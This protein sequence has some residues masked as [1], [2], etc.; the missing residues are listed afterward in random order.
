MG[1]LSLHISSPC[2]L[3]GAQARAVDPVMPLRPP[4]VRGALR[5]WFRMGAA[6]VLLVPE[7]RNPAAERN[8]I[9]LLHQAE[10]ELF[11]NTTVRSRVVI[12]APTGGQTIGL[13]LDEQKWPGLRYLG[14]GLFEDKRTPSQALITDSS[15]M[16]EPVRLPRLGPISLPI[17]LKPRGPNDRV[18]DAHR[19]LLAATLWLWLHLGGLGARS[20]RGWGSLRLAQPS[21]LLEGVPELRAKGP[22]DIVRGLVQGL[23]RATEIFREELP[24]LGIVLPSG[25]RPH[26][27]VRTI[28]GI[29]NV[30]VL[31]PADYSSPIQAL[32]NAGRLFRDFRSTLQR[33]KL[34]LRPLPDYF[35][36]KASLQTGKPARSVDRAAFGLPLPFYFRSLNG[37]KTKFMPQRDDG[38]RL[39]SPLIF[40]VLPLHGEDRQ[41]RYATVLVNLEERAP[42]LAAQR[43][44]QKDPL[45][46]VPTPNGGLV[47]E[48]IQWA[49]R[50]G[51]RT[52]VRARGRHS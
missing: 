51:E 17:D 6:S 14:Y 19:R 1:V 27:E 31:P 29:E 24:K 2:V 30:N 43:L 32:E 50:E 18:T 25:K 16:P 9:G 28:D 36:V 7:E 26:P 8:V 34:G 49:L 38:D 15:A 52:V 11:G 47:N 40:R 46:T 3:G 45:G 42:A 20:R 48:F 41:L 33:R 22:G 44:E 35:D 12:G 37:A 10:S 23:D 5:A 4:S 21:P 39:S 13:Q